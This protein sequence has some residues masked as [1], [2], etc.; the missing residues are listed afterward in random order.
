MEDI[1]YSC[2]ELD[3]SIQIWLS[4]RSPGPL[5][6]SWRWKTKMYV[7][8]LRIC[9]QFRRRWQANIRGDSR[10]RKVDMVHKKTFLSSSL[11]IATIVFI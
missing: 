1:V 8:E 3:F 9:V 2:L 10:L 11:L 7:W 5:W 4:D 6:Q